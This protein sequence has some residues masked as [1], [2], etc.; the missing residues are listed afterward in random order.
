M[1]GNWM[2]HWYMLW[3][4]Q[5]IYL[6]SWQQPDSF[7]LT[8]SSFHNRIFAYGTCMQCFL[9]WWF[10]NPYQNNIYCTCRCFE[11]NIT[12]C[13][14]FI[15][16][17]FLH[18]FFCWIFGINFFAKIHCICNKPNRVLDLLMWYLI[19]C[20]QI[21]GW[22]TK[23]YKSAHAIHML[24]AMAPFGIGGVVWNHSLP[25]FRKMSTRYGQYMQAFGA[26]DQ[27][28]CIWFNMHC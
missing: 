21:I 3:K 16:Y 18:Y 2:K 1:L 5:G 26:T 7:T 10:L 24:M 15:G 11:P 19:I 28:L 13:Y 8:C 20:N 12:N 17:C 23:K 27:M 9:F 14:K 4:Y 25:L 6:E 22:S